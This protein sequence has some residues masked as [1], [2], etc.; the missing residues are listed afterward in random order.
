MKK[1][2]I[3]CIFAFLQLI[4]LSAQQIPTIIPPSPAAQAFMRY[5]EIPVNYSTG[6]PSIEIPLY[7]IEGGKLKVPIS[8]SY[9]ASGIKVEDVASEVGLGWVLNCGGMISRTI[10]EQPDEENNSAKTYSNATQLLNTVATTAPIY[11]QS[12]S[13]YLGIDN[14]EQYFN[15]NFIAEDPLSDRFY[16]TLPNGMSGVFRLDYLNHSNVIKLPYRPL[17]IEK[18]I[19]SSGT[20]P[21]IE[22]F[23]ITDESGTSYT[24]TTFNISGKTTE[25]YLTRMT[26]SDGT[27]NI[28]FNYNRQSQG[29]YRYGFSL[30][31]HTQDVGESCSPINNP[32]IT[33]S[34]SQFPSLS[35]TFDTPVLQSIVSSTAIINFTYYK[36]R[37]DFNQLYRLSDVTIS[38]VS[39]PTTVIKSI[40]FSPKYFGSNST[41][42]RLGLDN[43]TISAPGNTQPQ[44]Y[45]F[46]Y[47]SQALPPYP[48]KMATPR[49]NEDFWG[50]NNASNS[51]TLLQ[52]D[53][54]SSSSDK[55]AFGGNRE[56][57]AGYYSRA[58]MI[59]EIKYPTGGKSVFQFDRNYAS[60]IYTYKSN[61]DG[62]VGGFRIGSITNYNEKN[63]VTNVKSYEYSGVYARP[64]TKILFD[65]TQFASIYNSYMDPREGWSTECWIQSTNDILLS[66]PIL[67]LEVG[68]G[69]PVMYSSV[70]EYNGTRTNSTG[71]TVYEYNPPYSPSDFESNPEHPAQFEEPRFYTA[72]HY[73]KGNYVP[74]LIS[75]TEYSFDGTHYHPVAKVTSEYT[76]L[77][78]QEFQTGIKLTKTHTYPSSV[79]V[80]YGGSFIQDYIQSVVAIDTK[81]YQEASLV[82]KT[83]NYIYNLTDS[84]KYVVNTTNLEYDPTYLRLTKQT[85]TTSVSGKDKVTQFTYP[86][87][88]STAPYTTMVQL[89]NIA[90]VIEQSEYIGTA[91]LQAKRNNYGYFQ[92]NAII[93]PAYVETKTGTNN[94]ETRLNYNAYDK[95]GNLTDVSKTGDLHTVYLWSYNYQYPVAKIEG[96]TY[97]QIL[98]YYSQTSIDNLAS[99]LNPTVDQLTAIRTA[100]AS[101]TALVT[102][103]AY[104]PLV[105]MVTATDPRGVTTNYTYDTF[106]RLYLARD[107]DMNLLSKYSYG[108]Q[109]APDNGQ[110]GYTTTTPTATITPGASSYS[111]GATGSASISS[112]S[113]GS[114][115]YT[116]SWYLKNASGSI[117]ASSVST[118]STSFSFICSQP[119]ILTIQ[120]IVEDNQT[121]LIYTASNNIT[122][123][124]PPCTISIQ[125]QFS[126]AAS[127]I[128]CNGATITIS[129]VIYS[130]CC[131][132]EVGTSY[133]VAYV[134]AG[135]RPSVTQTKTMFSN[136]NTWN[137]TFNSNGGVYVMIVS[138]TAISPGKTIYPGQCSFDL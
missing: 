53:L 60:N 84:T 5:G 98:N 104:K 29:A 101:Q 107:N 65:Y 62:Y 102:T 52:S 57:D 9:H 108:Y 35:N 63:E 16:Y 33:T 135:C 119:G 131:S 115:S 81:A 114:G 129:L 94:Y 95:K 69:L 133:Y 87:N 103:Y 78:A 20:Y 24:F 105:G 28:D 3:I 17:K 110:G 86:F 13:C 127:S 51:P 106:N 46:T 100:L 91:F 22:S 134:N 122:V 124:T 45:S 111:S 61:S 38:P 50:Y 37:S 47:E 4:N 89:N 126:N 137:V 93:A 1:I 58:C 19:N 11:N 25:W 117:L 27:D 43:V 54:I 56:A 123:N 79:G 42:Y 6:V 120:C 74:E 77:A 2:I 71:K 132:V 14:L 130:S 82:T 10:Y 138:G 30:T 49:F 23:K 36:D 72:S 118:T 113:G 66:N 12:C 85:T 125:N 7:T 48:I 15:S 31:S 96:L 8:I 75:K 44:K 64:I 92:S 59:K 73:D 26:S 136:G 21:R 121:G 34:I 88:Y 112:V 97:S 128:N 116:Y 18:T 109:N 83:G 70:T 68:S 67:P 41:D 99:A 55:A 80:G 90:P 40:H 39:S 32:V 76:K